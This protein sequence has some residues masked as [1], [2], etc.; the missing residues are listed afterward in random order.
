MCYGTVK[1]WG[2]VHRRT[3]AIEHKVQTVVGKDKIAL[4]QQVRIVFH[5]LFLVGH[6]GT[7]RKLKLRIK[8]QFAG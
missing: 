5:G 3:G 2:S 6:L 8:L 7:G 1:T 4:G